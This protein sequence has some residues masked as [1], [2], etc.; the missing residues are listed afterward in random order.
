[1]PEGKYAI[2]S[3]INISYCNME[4]SGFL[5]M[6]DTITDVSSLSLSSSYKKITITGNPCVTGSLSDGTACE[7]LTDEDRSIAT[8]KGWTLVE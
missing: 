1:M 7:T 5:E 8:T 6:I 4:R 3:E 2:R